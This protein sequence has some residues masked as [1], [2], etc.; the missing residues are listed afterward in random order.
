M[1][2]FVIVLYRDFEPLVKVTIKLLR[3]FFLVC[4]EKT[5]FWDLI[6]SKPSWYFSFD[7]HFTVK[8]LLFKFTYLAS[9]AKS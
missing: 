5:V 7:R 9:S 1:Y 4:D 8:Y 6:A 3:I 2:T